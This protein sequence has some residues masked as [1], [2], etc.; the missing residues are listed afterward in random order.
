M[1]KRNKL[2]K[3]SCPMCKPHK[4]KRGNRWKPQEEQTLKEYENVCLRY[5]RNPS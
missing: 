4:M 1:R 5:R 2:K 3:H